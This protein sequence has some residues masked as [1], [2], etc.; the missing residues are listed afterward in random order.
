M[1]LITIY[2]SAIVT[3]LSCNYPEPESYL[4]PYK[5]VGKVNVIFNQKLGNPPLYENGRRL[6]KIPSNGILLTGFKDEEGF[7]DHKYYYVDTNGNK[8]PLKIFRYDYN[9]DGT[10]KWI[11][12]DSNEIGIFGDG[13]NGVYGNSKYRYQEFKVSS[14]RFLDSINDNVFFKK[15]QFYLNDNFSPDTI[16]SDTTRTER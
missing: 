8:K 14:F 7:V 4:I 5:Y 9:K 10:V 12:N 16:K 6:Y 13:T 3:I 1:K 2:F 11:I 15:V